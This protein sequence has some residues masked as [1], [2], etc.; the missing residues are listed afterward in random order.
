MIKQL[1]NFTKKKKTKTINAKKTPLQY[2][3]FV[4]KKI[5][6]NLYFI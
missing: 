4:R 3:N 1:Q 2:C 5:C 6:K